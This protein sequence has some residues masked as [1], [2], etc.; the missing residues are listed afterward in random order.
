MFLDKTKCKSLS[1]TI[2]CF[3]APTLSSKSYFGGS[4]CCLFGSIPFP[5]SYGGFGTILNKAA[6][7]HLSEPIYCNNAGNTISDHNPICDQIAK[8]QVGEASLFK[9]GMSVFQLFYVYSALKDFCMHSDWIL[10]Y[11]LEVFLPH[12]ND[13]NHDNEEAPPHKNL[14]GIANYPSCGNLTVTTGNVRP[15]TLFSYSCHNLAPND[16]EV[17]ALSSF[18]MSPESYSYLPKLDSTDSDVAMGRVTTVK[19]LESKERIQLP[20]LFL[21]GADSAATTPV[22]GIMYRFLPKFLFVCNMIRF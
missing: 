20:N 19:K 11:M 14:I 8:N 6:I 15:C 21:I 7:K 4:L 1:C 13:V 18:A 5:I 10:S 16:M 9:D 22:G 2:F 17:W 3:L 12:S